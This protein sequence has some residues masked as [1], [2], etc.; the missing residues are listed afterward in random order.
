V[1]GDGARASRSSLESERDQA[2]RELERARGI[3]ANQGFLAKAPPA[4]VDEEREKERLYT[5]RLA[6]IEA[7]LA[8][9]A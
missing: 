9:L 6:D 4:K 2:L 7:R 5:A 1:A 8:E 3:L